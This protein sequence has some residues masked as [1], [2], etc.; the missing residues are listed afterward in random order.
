MIIGLLLRL[1]GAFVEELQ[2]ALSGPPELAM[3]GWEAAVA[4]AFWD[5]QIKE[6]IASGLFN[7]VAVACEE[8]VVFGGD[9]EDGT[10][11]EEK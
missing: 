8:G 7:R 6:W 5:L 10:F 4:A 11:K 9:E 3:W 2:S 1:H